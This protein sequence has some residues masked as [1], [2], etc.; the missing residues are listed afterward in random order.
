MQPA[1]LPEF[2]AFLRL[3][4]IALGQPRRS[5]HQFALGLAI[6]RQ[7][8]AIDAH[9]RRL[10]QRHRYPG[11]DPV[12][13]LL[14]LAAGQ[15]LVVDVRAGDQRAGFRHAIGSRQLDTARLGGIVEGTVQRTAADDH[16]Q[17]AKVMALGTRGIEHHLQDGRYTVG[18]ADLLLLDQLA[19]QLRLVAPR[20][21]LLDAQ[22]GGDIRNAPGMHMEHRSNRHVD[23]VGTQQAHAVEAA[24]HTGRRQGVQ[25]QLPMSEI[26]AL[27]IAGGAGGVEGGGHRVFIEIGEVVART[28]GRQQLLVLADQTR[29]FGGFL[30]G[31]GQQQGLLDRGQL[32]GYAVVEGHELTVDQDELILGV[33]HGV[34]NLLRRQA[35]I[36]GVQHRTEHGD[37]EHAFEVAVAVPVHHRHG[38]A[39]LDPGRRQHIGQACNPLVEGCIAVAQRVAIDDF[40][41]FLVAHAG[42]QQTLDQQRIL[43]GVGRGR[44]DAS[45]QHGEHLSAGYC[46]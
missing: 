32:R 4:E 19:Q 39:G 38:V 22:H 26:H 20:I 16:L 37:G 2:L 1:M 7:H 42:Q 46:F 28:G 24:Q 3:A 15:Q 21:H 12:G 17:P 9:D 30:L 11:L 40:T 23:I 18:K 13:D 44:D 10:D 41:G 36:D 5:Q 29:Q 8:V 27:G 43:M 33:V 45:W 31:I 35:D 6:R 14:I 34:E 25:H